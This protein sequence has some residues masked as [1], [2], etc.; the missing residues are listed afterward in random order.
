MLRGMK[1]DLQ[2]WGPI[3]VLA[4]ATVLI[5]VLGGLV[6]VIAGHETFRAFLDDLKWVAGALGAGAGLGRGLL[7]AG[8]Q[9][10]DAHVHAAAL[11]AVGAGRSEG[12]KADGFVPPPEEG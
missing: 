9:V 10:A 5:L 11:S 6:N 2:K 8:G 7:A 1:I 12:E 3:T 4:V